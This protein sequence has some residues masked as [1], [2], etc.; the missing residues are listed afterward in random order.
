MRYVLFGL[1]VYFIKN[2]LRFEKVLCVYGLG[3]FSGLILVGWIFIVRITHPSASAPFSIFIGQNHPLR[4]AEIIM[5][6]IHALSVL[7][8]LFNR[9]YDW[10]IKLAFFFIIAGQIMFFLSKFDGLT[11]D[12]TRVFVHAPYFNADAGYY[13]IIYFLTKGILYTLMMTLSTLSL[14]FIVYKL[15][16]HLR[17]EAPQEL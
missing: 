10:M 15:T 7:P 1:M 5:I 2:E 11:V 4:Y 9:H 6:S 3:L 17:K 13:N 14:G 16:P 12:E 8:L